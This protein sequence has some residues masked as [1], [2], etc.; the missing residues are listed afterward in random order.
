MNARVAFFAF[1]AWI[2]APAAALDVY[3][4]DP[5]HSQPQ[6][7]ARHIGFSNQH[8]NFGKATG[9]VTLDRAAG[10]IS[11]AARRLK[12][13]RRTLQRKLQKHPPKV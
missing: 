3:V 2:A 7:E 12:M 4:I 13:H 9:K 1:A 11:E 5:V 10:N 8:G 6:W